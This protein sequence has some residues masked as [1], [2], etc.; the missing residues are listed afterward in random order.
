M[1]LVPPL[2]FVLLFGCAENAST[3]QTTPAGST[4]SA[5]TGSTTGS[6]TTTSTTTSSPGTTTDTLEVVVGG[7]RL[8]SD[9]GS[10]AYVSWEQGLPAPAQ[11]QYSF[12]D[13]VWL[14][15]PQFDA[16]AGAHEQILL[17]IPFD[18]ETQ[19]RVIVDSTV[20]EGEAFTTGPLPGA[21]PLGTL[22]ESREEL[23]DSSSSYVLSSVCENEGSWNPGNYWTFIVDRQGRP[24]W[25]QVAPE[26]HWT[27]F[28]QVSVTGRYILW[29]ESTY[30]LDW[31]A[32]GGAGS[33]IHRQYL[34]AEIEEIAADGLV[35]AFVEHP[36]GTLAWGSE[37]H[38]PGVEALVELPPGAETPTVLWRCDEDYPGSARAYCSSNG[39]YYEE[40]T[41]SYL[42]SFW[43]ESVVLEVS[44]A[45][46]ETRWWA[47]GADDGYSFD[48]PDAQFDFQ[49]GIS[50]TDS[51]TLLV[52]TE[53]GSGR[54]KVTMVRE[55]AVDHK[56]RGL[57]EVW[58][59]GLDENEGA[60]LNG[61]AWRLPGGNTLHATGSVGTIKEITPDGELAWFLEFESERGRLLGRTDMIDDLYELV[62]PPE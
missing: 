57:T 13:G 56:A 20:N 10:L 39:L 21:L 17:G 38:V 51:G 28:A 9:I 47:G 29:D 8:H 32:N 58:S 26:E 45:D 60:G 24:V 62:P 3:E 40:S 34:D 33:T 43:D 55:Y 1:Y 15:S 25:A 19:W 14:S 22:H 5:T 53:G 37:Y 41:D 27:L 31:G 52:S 30:W 23:W 50:Y 4:P 59:Y 35:H 36:D 2:L 18:T 7:W 11:V 48:P 12:D 54:D 46:G 44:G 49:H 42:Y 61:Q 16:A 6:T